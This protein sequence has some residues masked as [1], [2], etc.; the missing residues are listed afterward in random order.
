VEAKFEELPS[1][2]FSGTQLQANIKTGSRRDV[3]VIPTQ[4]V[5]NQNMVLLEDGKAQ[6]IEIGSKNDVWTEVI[7][8]ITNEHILINPLN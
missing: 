3:L 7:S 4:Y 8:G 2:M 5:S 6:Q 1:K